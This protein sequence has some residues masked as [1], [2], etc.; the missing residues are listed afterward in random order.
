MQQFLRV[1]EWSMQAAICMLLLVRIEICLGKS[2]WY[3]DFRWER[4]VWWTEE[5]E[6]IPPR[7]QAELKAKGA[8]EREAAATA[9]C[10]EAAEH[11]QGMRGEIAALQRRLAARDLAAGA[12]S[13]VRAALA[14][15]KACIVSRL[16]RFASSDSNLMIR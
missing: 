11:L 14:G 5:A 16:E 9:R 12:A 4:T 3:D 6:M 13:E 8:L 10:Q 7:P 1:I 2:T 15:S